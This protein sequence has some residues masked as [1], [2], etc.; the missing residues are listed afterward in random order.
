MSRIVVASNRVAVA[1]DP[2]KTTAKAGGLAVALE[3]AL[4]ATG[5]MWFGWSGEI[6]KTK[7]RCPKIV[8]RGGVTYA[9]IDLTA[10]DRNEYYNGFANRTLWPLFHYRTDLTAFDRAFYRGY[11]RVNAAFARH[12]AKLLRPDDLVWVHDYH[13]IPLGQAMRTRG[14][15][16]RMGFFLHIPFPPAQ[17]LLTLPHHREL[18]EALLSYD[19]IGFQTATDLGSFVDYVENIA[20]GQIQPDGTVTAYG[21]TSH[22]GAFPIGIDVNEF[23]AVATGSV[24]QTHYQRTR[25][26]LRTDLIIGVDRLDYSKGMNERFLAYEQM[27]AK[28]PEMRGQITFM[29]IAPIS[30]GEV[31]EYQIIRRELEQLAGHINGRFAEPDW[32]PLRYINRSFERRQ[33]AGL[34]RAAKVGLVTPFRDG[35][36]LVA[37][38]YVAAQVGE[39][40]GILVLSK[41]AG[42]AWLLPE[43]LIVNPYDTEEVTDTLWQAIRMPLKERRRRWADNMDSLRRNDLDTWRDNFLAALVKSAGAV[44][45]G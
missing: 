18:V 16:H 39:D 42:A 11:T 22:A 10:A 29:Q 9:T 41:F 14:C 12:L 28:Y 35:M 30:R 40:P 6:S 15:H 8:D 33:L 37:L 44:A 36:N 2:A 23:A 5:G 20:G 31:A 13:L 27:L 43:A 38:E 45:A 7:P 34:Y 3:V 19:L 25:R 21:R 1:R 17:L 32:M 4:R 26:S 24:A